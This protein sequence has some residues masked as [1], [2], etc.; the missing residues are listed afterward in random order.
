LESRFTGGSIGTRPLLLEL[1]CKTFR[2]LDLITSDIRSAT[3][4]TVDGIFDSCEV[5]TQ[6]R[7]SLP[8]APETPLKPIT[9]FISPSPLL[10]SKEK[11]KDDLFLLSDC[12]RSVLSELLGYNIHTDVLK[13]IIRSASSSYF[14]FFMVPVAVTL[15]KGNFK[16]IIKIRT[17]N[18]KQNARTSS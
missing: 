11:G 3:V 2:F 5:L 15:S 6:I 13:K 12:Y 1:E 10:T 16:S 4:L 9:I 17:S 14:Y 18:C 7:K 8:D